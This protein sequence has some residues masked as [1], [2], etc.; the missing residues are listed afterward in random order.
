MTLIS[1]A[2]APLAQV[3]ARRLGHPGLPIVVIDHPVGD[4]DPNKVRQKGVDA[5][6]AC[7]KIFVTPPDALDREFRDKRFPPA[8]HV[9]PKF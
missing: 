4:P 2:F 5:A 7:A 3:I 9:V 6:E 1:A 8:P